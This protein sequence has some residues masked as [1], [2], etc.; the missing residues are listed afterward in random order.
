MRFLAW[1][2]LVSVASAAV[3]AVTTDPLS[4]L[5]SPQCTNLIFG[6]E[7]ALAKVVVALFFRPRIVF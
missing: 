1:L 4:S 6:L 5:L 7:P 3:A 2:F